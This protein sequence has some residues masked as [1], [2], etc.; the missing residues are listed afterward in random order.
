M[1]RTVLHLGFSRSVARLGS[2]GWSRVGTL[3]SVPLLVCTLG[4]PAAAQDPCPSASAVDAEAGWFAY[5][6]GRLDQAKVRFQSALDRCENDQ[7]ARAGLGYVLLREG[8]TQESARLF[9]VVVRAEPGNADALV[10]LGLVSWRTGDLDAVRRHFERVLEYVPDHPTALDYLERLGGAAPRAE[11]EADRAWSSGDTE[12]A[13]E[14]YDQRLAADAD[15]GVALLRRGLI[16]GWDGEYDRSLELLEHLVALDAGNLDARLARAR[17]LAWSGR[18]GDATR[19]VDEVLGMEPGNPDAL[20]TLALFH[21]WAGRADEALERYDELL[22]LAPDYPTAPRERAQALAWAER[23]EQSI[24]VYETL[25]EQSPDDVDSRLGLARAR[26]F[27]GDFEG[28]LAEYDRVLEMAPGHVPALSGRARTLG[29]SG[30]LMDAERAAQEAVAANAGSGEAWGVLGEV[31]R[32]QRRAGAAVEVLRRANE[33]APNDAAIRDQLRYAEE[34]LATAVRSTVRGE[35]DSDG[36]RM[37]TT[38]LV[39]GYHPIPR[40]SVRA[41]AYRRELSQD[42]S[43]AQLQRWA[44][45]VS[46]TGT[47]EMDPGWSLTVGAGGSRTDGFEDPTFFSYRAAVRSPQRRP[48][49]VTLEFVSVGVDETAAMAERGVRGTQFLLSAAWRPA[50]EWRVDGQVGLGTYDATES[51]GRRSFLLTATRTMGSDLFLGAGFRGFSFEKNLF[52]GYFDPDFYG[53]FEVWGTWVRRPS[54]WTF[55][56][57]VAPGVE[58]VTSDGDPSVT[59]RGNGRVAYRIAGPSEV[60]LGVSYSTA[61]VTTFASGGDGYDYASLVLGIRWVLE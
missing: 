50:L 7:Y 57:E 21:S 52:D 49:D 59:V 32:W 41:E 42:L 35:D 27:A 55:V 14:L 48:V 33:L 30:R 4:S 11:D 2:P 6:D 1:K 51:N 34:A 12:R 18:L 58:Q 31:Y 45:G 56:V 29:W 40:L 47:Y 38:S 20:A 19:A 23:Y 44:M 46:L 61:S 36:N 15:D 9:Q 25:V 60:S 16:H 37:V 24:G 3:L 53:V 17:V 54:P 43:F 26:G 8:D 13:R 5:A 10:G 28:A 39:G 22:A